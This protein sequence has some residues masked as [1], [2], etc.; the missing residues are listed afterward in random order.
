[1]DLNEADEK[2]LNIRLN[3][4]TGE[5][6]MDLLDSDF[7]SED[8]QEW[9]LELL[10]FESEEQTEKEEKELISKNVWIP[11]CLFESNNLYDIPTLKTEYQANELLLPFKGW[12]MESRQKSTAAVWHFYVDDYR[13]E[14]LWSNPEKIVNSGCTSIVEPNLSLFD[15]TPTSYGIHLIYKKRWLA[16]LMQKFG[17][18]VFADLNVSLKF[19]EYNKLGIPQGY[20]SFCTRGYAGKEKYLENEI[21]IA[22]EISGLDTPFMVVY[23]GG[24]KCKE[25][26]NKHNLIFVNDL[27]TEKNIHNGKN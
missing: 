24:N 22:K 4:N 11:D 6:D 23:G 10:S 2:E 12:G 7:D 13:F 1:V 27:M 3:A 17:I 16:R 25:I 19:A 5:W 18:T 8:L 20:N 14:A 9:G 21:A 26:A 15:T